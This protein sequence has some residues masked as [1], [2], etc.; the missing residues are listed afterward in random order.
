MIAGRSRQVRRQASGD[1]S[2][3][4]G[5]DY[6]SLIA[7][8]FLSGSWLHEGNVC[9]PNAGAG[10][11]GYIDATQL[12]AFS[13]ISRSY[14]QLIA[15][16][17]AT[18]LTFSFLAKEASAK[19]IQ[20]ALYAANLSTIVASMTPTLTTAFQAV[21][22][23]ATGLTPGTVYAAAILTNNAGQAAA[24]I[25]QRP[26]VTAGGGV[27][28]LLGGNYLRL[29]PQWGGTS[30]DSAWD[31][32][33][34]FPQTN[35]FAECSIVT[36]A[37]RIAVESFGN[38]A[39]GGA[40]AVCVNGRPFASGQTITAGMA[41]DEFSMGDLRERVVDV[42]SGSRNVPPAGNYIRAIY[43]PSGQQ[44]RLVTTGSVDQQW[45]GNR[46][47]L[48]WGD[49]ISCG[50]LS[51]APQ[52]DAWPLALRRRYPGSVRV[53]SYGGR[54]L[55]VDASTATA[56]AAIAQLL[57]RGNPTDLWICLGVNDYAGNLWS[58]ASFGTAYAAVL[59]AIHASAPQARVFCQTPILRS[60]ETANG[61]GSTLGDYRT[62]ITTACSTRAWTSAIDG[63]ATS[64][65]PSTADLV[66]GTHP[67]SAGQR[68][69]ADA[70]INALH[71]AGVL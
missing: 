29:V 46:S 8:D 7:G 5:L 61:S 4:T 52:L 69:Y 22:L 36:D 3:G 71:G 64:R 62:Q 18:S 27:T 39:G 23:F 47:L 24:P 17:G 37:N 58:A 68:K 33:A 54:S 56:Q 65:F 12:S 43:I 34:Q 13:G 25:I 60:I 14:H 20:V 11:D 28:G 19:A 49:S 55:N 1:P 32:T 51:S 30:G 45:G 48:I 6:T 50:V 9:W 35:P 41:I 66:D 15:P 57:A 59:D 21:S 26:T 44:L 31:A 40:V 63:T 67:S 53:E 38:N 10:V 16:P 42:R 70:V 2:F